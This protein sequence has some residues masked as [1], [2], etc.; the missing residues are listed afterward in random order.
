[1]KLIIM[2]FILIA[3]AFIQIP[4]LIRKKQSKDLWAYCV[5]YAI[6]AILSILS[7]AN[8]H[9]PSPLSLI[10]TIYKPINALFMKVVGRIL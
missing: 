10:I 1:M 6:A 5:I 2:I 7:T 3:I 4:P 8:I 9:I